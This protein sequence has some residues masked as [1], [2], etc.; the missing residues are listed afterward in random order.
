MKRVALSGADGQLG[1][2]LRKSLLQ[3]GFLLKSAGYE[4]LPPPYCENEEIVLGNLAERAVADKL[5][6]GV[7]V[8]IHM[9]GSSVE[10]PLDEIIT[11]NL[12]ALY[13]IY[14]GARR[15]KVRRII[16]ASSNHAIGMHSVNDPLETDCDF[17][18][19]SLYGL[20][21]MWGEGMA[22]LYWDKHGIE[23]VCIRI[24]S[25]LERPQ[26]I[27]HLST[28][29]GHDDFVHL[30]RQS[31]TVPDVGFVVVWGVSANQRNYWSNSKA[32][33]L[34]YVPVQ[35]AEDYA[36]EFAAVADLRDP[37]AMRYQGGAFAS[38]DFTSAEQRIAAA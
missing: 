36:H 17:R 7:D 5:L 34:S 1:T 22:R 8:L 4:A 3:D 28:W 31:V 21:K 25:C 33:V 38:R 13:Q 35:N 23:S 19:D 12:D 20:S 11:N 9:A 16:F 10:R 26:E 27:R 15:H 2:L 24:G 37:V 30:I 32:A 18:P 29:L 6:S 14:E